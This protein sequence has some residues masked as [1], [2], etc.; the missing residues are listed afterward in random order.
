MILGGS[1]RAQGHAGAAGHAGVAHIQPAR[2]AV[3]PDGPSA[4]HLGAA[5][6]GVAPQ[7]G[8]VSQVRAVNGVIHVSPRKVMANPAIT[9]GISRDFEATSGID[10]DNVP[11]LGFDFPHLAATRPGNTGRHQRARVGSFIPFFNGGFFFPP[12]PVVVDEGAQALP[13]ESEPVQ[14]TRPM[15]TERREPEAV[16]EQAEAG[17]AMDNT[18]YVFVRRDGSV[19]FAVAYS[20]E[21]GTLRY[22]T[23]Q[24]IRG[25]VGRDTLDLDATRRFNEERGLSFSFP[26]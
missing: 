25:S 7:S 23:G 13:A 1:A 9:P 10:F 24:G 6:V 15:R 26:A 12:T 14:T 21:K 11:G 22:I 3:A 19:F 8:A 17:V 2:V 4:L 20:W 5:H 16:A 18:Q